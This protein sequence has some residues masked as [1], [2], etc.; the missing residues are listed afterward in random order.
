MGRAGAGSD[1][2]FSCSSAGIGWA[3][4]PGQRQGEAVRLK[5]WVWG[6][7]LHF[8]VPRVWGRAGGRRRG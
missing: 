1:D 4:V 2:G 6:T 3:G 8:L 5:G 7:T